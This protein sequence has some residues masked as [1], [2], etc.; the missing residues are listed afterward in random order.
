VK[1]VIKKRRREDGGGVWTIVQCVVTGVSQ[2]Q[3]DLID[4]SN[5]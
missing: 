1:G 2:W 4:A 3:K 5:K